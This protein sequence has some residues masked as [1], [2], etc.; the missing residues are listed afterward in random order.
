MLI[1][2]SKEIIEHEDFSFISP[3][4]FPVMC[5]VCTWYFLYR[6]KSWNAD[7]QQKIK[8]CRSSGSLEASIQNPTT[9]VYPRWSFPLPRAR[10]ELNAAQFC[11]LS[12]ALLVLGWVC[13]PQ[14]LELPS[15]C[16]NL[17]S[18]ISFCQPKISCWAEVF[19]CFHFLK[20]SQ[21]ACS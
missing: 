20:A 4:T 5:S 13:L 2:V 19:F 17:T 1:I 18:A 3:S 15:V 16:C 11:P 7:C 14:H 6:G 12:R 9:R 10:S 21:G 8:V